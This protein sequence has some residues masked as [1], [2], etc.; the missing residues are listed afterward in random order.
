MS[1]S[2]TMKPFLNSLMLKLCNRS[3]QSASF[4]LSNV[5]RGE[6]LHLD[7][8]LDVL[9]NVCCVIMSFSLDSTEHCKPRLV[10]KRGAHEAF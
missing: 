1:Q 9:E 5:L 8:R 2:K 6:S 7:E 3:K 10:Y 4:D